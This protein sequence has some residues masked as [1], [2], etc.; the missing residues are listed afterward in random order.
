V[1]QRVASH[2][3][4]FLPERALEE[5]R[6]AARRHGAS[7]ESACATLVEEAL[8]VS[9][10]KQGF[11]SAVAGIPDA[12]RILGLPG[13]AVEAADDRGLQIRIDGRRRLTAW[14]EIDPARL[15]ALIEHSIPQPGADDRFA[16]GLFLLRA[17]RPAE[18]SRQFSLLR[19][20]PL[21]PSAGRYLY[22]LDR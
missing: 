11:R 7:P 21:W 18:A 4:R 22:G 20:T 9:A 12:L 13:D 14:D 6:D 10:L 3:G 16:L 1:E 8:R 17:S 2:L 5:A 19:N 15:A